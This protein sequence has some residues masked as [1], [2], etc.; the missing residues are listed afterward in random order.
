MA[1]LH[2]SDLLTIKTNLHML[3]MMRTLYVQTFDES[4]FFEE[5]F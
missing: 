3:S 5:Y 2:H 1:K 4:Y